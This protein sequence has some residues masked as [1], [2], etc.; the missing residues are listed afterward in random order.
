MLWVALDSV[1]ISHS[2]YPTCTS[3][4][5]NPIDSVIKSEV[6]SDL[7]SYLMNSNSYLLS[8]SITK[9]WKVLENRYLLM[10]KECSA[11]LLLRA[12]IVQQCKSR[13]EEMAVHLSSS[14]YGTNVP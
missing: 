6:R 14:I 1:G 10:W 4:N 11:V 13:S 5:I 3:E 2:Q 9:S 8:V 12:T 7:I